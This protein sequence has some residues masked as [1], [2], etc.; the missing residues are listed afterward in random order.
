[1]LGEHV[2]RVHL[3]QA[4]ALGLGEDLSSAHVERD[5]A[6]LE[7]VPRVIRV[8][9][10]AAEDH[11]GEELGRH[12]ELRCSLRDQGEGRVDEDAA[13]V[14]EDGVEASF[15]SAH[16]SS[17]VSRRWVNPSWSSTGMPS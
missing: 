16:G 13:E 9:V 1:E 17:P 14:E 7:A 11:R 2:E 10:V 5:L 4:V 8:V 15:G 3:A 6:A 12:L